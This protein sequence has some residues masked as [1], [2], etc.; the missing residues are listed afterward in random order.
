MMLIPQSPRTAVHEKYVMQYLRA[1]MKATLTYT[2]NQVVLLHCGLCTGD[3]VSFLEI[4]RTLWLASEK[5]AQQI[6]YQAVRKTR[7]A[8]PGSTLEN[9]IISYRLAYYPHR[10]AAVYIDPR[11][12]IPDWDHQ[13]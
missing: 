7:E 11:A 8:I 6:Y 9:W 3:P 12:P 2:E 1:L 13:C 5:E 10:E 4:A